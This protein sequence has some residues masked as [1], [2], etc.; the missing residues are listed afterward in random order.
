MS[1]YIFILIALL[2]NG[3][4]VFNHFGLNSA[5]LCQNS[6]NK[7]YYFVIIYIEMLTGIRYNK[8]IKR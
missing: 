1:L 4:F 3:V 7:C 6:Q 8:F 2:N 5:R